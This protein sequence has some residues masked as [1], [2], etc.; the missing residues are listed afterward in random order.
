MLA[1]LL[2]LAPPAAADEGMWLFNQPPRELLKKKYKFDLDDVWLKRAMLASIRFNSG[3]SGSFVSPD[4]LV[5]TNHHVGSDSLQK[6]STPTKNYYRDGFYA[7]NRDEEL[8]CPD[9]ELNVLQS[10]EDVTGRV[11]A[12]V[13]PNLTTAQ[14]AAAR[15][16]AMAQIEQE[17]LTA[18]KLRSDVVTLY[19]G[20]QYHLYRYKKYTDVRLVM[21]PEAAIAFFGGDTDNFEYPRFN[22]DVCFFRVYE[23]GKPA[24]IEHYFKWS[25]K[26][27][28]EGD[29]VFVSGHPGS[30]NRLET[31]A[32][33]KHRRDLTLPYTLTRLR[34]LEALLRQYAERGP[35]E[36]RQADKDLYPVA[37]ARKALTGQY[38][39]L[40]DPGV[41]ARKTKDEE[42]LQFKVGADAALK[43]A[44]GSAWERIAAVQKTMA[45]FEKEYSLLETGD[46]F[47]S[48]YFRI[49]RTLVRLVEEQA[50]PDAQR[51]REYRGS[52]LE[53]LKFLLFSP[54]PIS[55]DLERVKLAGSLAFLAE[56]LGGEHPLVVKALAGKSPAARA[57][58]LTAGTTVGDPNGAAQTRR[59]RPQDAGGI[60]RHHV[61]VCPPAGW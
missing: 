35:E 46:A 27:P 14:A 42:Y 18:T 59:Q 13:T 29:V 57:A 56:Q 60:D 58:E 32:R 34:Y 40:L 31:L 45:V 47:N 23:D 3:A 19:Q 8:K 43:K 28:V 9:L 26:G 61:S 55:A 17:S 41:I 54:A 20:G 11:Q 16:A 44:Y 52:A 10:I 48:R 22:L 24:K 30:T 36:A 6:L 12:A 25:P 51:L 50:K 39:G 2:E 15:R 7:K 5:V 21:A 33:L 37:N 4:G 38:H 49:A 1:S 53:S